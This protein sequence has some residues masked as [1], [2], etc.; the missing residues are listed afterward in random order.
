MQG[1]ARRYRPV[2]RKTHPDS[3]AARRLPGNRAEAAAQYS[4]GA[5]PDI[6]EPPRRTA[7]CPAAAQPGETAP[8]EP[9]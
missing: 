5:V 3:W 1:A 6:D 4:P 7:A 2:A 9:A 8:A